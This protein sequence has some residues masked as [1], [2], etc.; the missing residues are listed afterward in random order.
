MALLGLATNWKRDKGREDLLWHIAQR[1]PGE[2]WALRELDQLYEATG[3]TYGLHRVYAAMASND[4][5]NYVAQNNLA[6]TCLLLRVDL[7][8][9]HELAKDV[10]TQH[11]DEIIVVFTYAYSL[12]LQGRTREGLAILAKQ[13]PQALETPS[14]ALY[15][16]L[17]LSA[18]GETNQATKYL[19][20]ARQAKL[21]PEEKTLLNE[22][23]KM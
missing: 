13:K 2:R 5:R 6:A 21:L 8:K 3:N 16:G 18:A 1:F 15:Y 11:P 10:F 17:L 20:L 4:P 14:V 19:E 9:A 22:A 12:H 23:A 7:P